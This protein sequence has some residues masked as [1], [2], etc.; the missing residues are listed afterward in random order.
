MR[1]KFA[2]LAHN[3]FVFA[4]ANRRQ[5]NLSAGEITAGSTTPKKVIENLREGGRNDE[6]ARR[7]RVQGLERPGRGNETEFVLSE[8]N[9]RC[10]RC[11]LDVPQLVAKRCSP[12]RQPSCLS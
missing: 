6:K 10:A 9:A 3:S 2:P 1:W 4:R 12:G 5:I 8:L 11:P 7:S